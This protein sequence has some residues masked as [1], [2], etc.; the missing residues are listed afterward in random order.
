MEVEQKQEGT[1]ARAD[2]AQ[3]S[4]MQIVARGRFWGVHDRQGR[5]VCVTVYKKGA[6]EVVRRLSLTCRSK[7]VNKQRS[8]RPPRK[9]SV[10]ARVLTKRTS[11]ETTLTK[12]TSTEKG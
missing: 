8:N 5:L 10:P 2:P 7:G 12:T 4:G 3:T 6:R 9:G 11:M 1:P